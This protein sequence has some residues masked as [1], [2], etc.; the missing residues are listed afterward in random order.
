MAQK[1][2][3]LGE[4]NRKKLLQTFNTKWRDDKYVYPEDKVIERIKLN[5][6]NK[7]L[8]KRLPD[9]TTMPPFYKR[10]RLALYIYGGYM[11]ANHFMLPGLKEYRNQ[12]ISDHKD[13]L[14]A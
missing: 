14:K 5:A 4:Q 8:W 13:P 9:Q 10:F 7:T 2:I 1:E 6:S 3:E 12:Y 11:F